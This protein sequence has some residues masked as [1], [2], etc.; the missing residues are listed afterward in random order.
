MVYYR[1]VHKFVQTK[2]RFNELF[3]KKEF[4][5]KFNDGD[6]IDFY[7]VKISK[8]K[9]FKLLGRR[10]STEFLP[11]G[12]VTSDTICNGVSV[13]ASVWRSPR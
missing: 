13:T 7:E 10:F 3:T 11:H 1:C 12:G 8:N 6:L 4:Y 2:A 9:T 5:K